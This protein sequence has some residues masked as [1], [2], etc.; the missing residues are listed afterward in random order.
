M[1]SMGKGKF[2]G[3]IKANFLSGPDS[4]NKLSSGFFK[5]DLL[6]FRRDPFAIADNWSLMAGTP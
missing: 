5:V 1:N 2:R 6:F 4:F 3:A